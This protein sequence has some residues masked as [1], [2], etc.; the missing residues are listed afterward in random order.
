[1]GFSSDTPGGNTET[2]YVD[3]ISGAGLASVD[4]ISNTIVPVGDFSNDPNL[5]GQSCELTGTGS[6]LLYGY[7]T[8][9]PYVRVAQLDKTNANEISDNQLLN[10]PPPDDWAFSF[11]GGDFYLY[12]YPIPANNS[13]Y[14]SVVYYSPTTGAVNL[15]YIA[16][17]GF[18]IIGAGV[19][20][21][22]PTTPCLPKTCAQAGAQCGPAGDGCG[23]I[24][25]CGA[26]PSAQAC[27][28]GACVPGC[29]PKSCSGQGFTCGMQGDGCGDAINCG[30]C[31][32]GQ[33]CNDGAC[34][35]GTCTPKTCAEQ[36][37]AC[38]SVGD[39][40]GNLINCG[41]CSPGAICGGMT[42]GQC[43]QPPCTPKNCAQ[44]GYTCGQATNG[45]GDIINCGTCVS[46]QTCG[47]GSMAN[48][49]GAPN[50]G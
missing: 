24:I 26:C 47:G 21:C 31:P 23:N 4:M 3:G 38:G 13:P 18:T 43:Y 10:F 30:T 45:C 5:T 41:T 42:P 49:C 9:S 46:P 50:P 32:S 34:T 22:A 17:V 1:M 36:G 44:L 39:G 29:T 20:T 15:S 48:V 25:M 35:S 14:S 19:S 2:L 7:F 8:T 27:V 6:A 33:A 40:C 37:Y 11:W 12:A 16:D 28:A